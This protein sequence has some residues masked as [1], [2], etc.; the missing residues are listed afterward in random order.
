MSATHCLRL[1]VL[2]F[3]L[4]VGDVNCENTQR[5]YVQHVQVGQAQRGVHNDNRDD[6]RWRE[7]PIVRI[8]TAGYKTSSVDRL[9]SGSIYPTREDHTTAS[10]SSQIIR[11]YPVTPEIQNVPKSQINQLKPGFN[12]PSVIQRRSDVAY[13][14]PGHKAFPDGKK[15]HQANSDSVF[16]TGAVQV[17]SQIYNTRMRST[18]SFSPVQVDKVPFSLR[19]NNKGAPFYSHGNKQ[20]LNIQAVKSQKMHVNPIEQNIYPQESR[21]TTRPKSFNQGRTNFLQTVLKPKD[22]QTDSVVEGQSPDRNSA[23][24]SDTKTSFPAWSPRAYSSDMTSEARGYTHVRRLKPAFD[25]KTPQASSRKIWETGFF[26]CNT[27]FRR[28]Q[29]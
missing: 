15:I 7:P 18:G 4:L 8:P 16:S 11:R 14:R 19:H 5:G 6:T 23:G 9:Q 25:K 20:S 10:K 1:F 29:P 13:N 24:K 28:L 22:K 2:C 21:L 26:T 17:P 3:W 27:Q 12:S